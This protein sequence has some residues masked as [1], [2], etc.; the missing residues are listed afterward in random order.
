M[1]YF[2]PICFLER[3]TLYAHMLKQFIMKETPM[4]NFTWDHFRVFSLY[5]AYTTS[6]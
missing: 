1:L 2:L 4:K 6:V 5:R 3:T